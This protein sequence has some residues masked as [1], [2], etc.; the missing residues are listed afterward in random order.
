[1]TETVVVLPFIFVVLSLLIFLGWGM[2]RWHR[3]TQ[4]DRYVAWQQATKAPGPRAH[5]PRTGQLNDAFYDGRV[6][7]LTPQAPRSIPEEKAADAW[8]E[9]VAGE[10]GEAGRL[11]ERVHEQLP[12]RVIAAFQTSHQTTVPLWQD[13]DGPIYHQHTRLD[14]DWRF[15]NHVL[16]DRETTRRY[17]FDN[18]A[19]RWHPLKKRDEG[20]GRFPPTLRRLSAIRDQFLDRLDQQ[21]RP[22]AGGREGQLA[23]HW[24]RLYLQAPDYRGPFMPDEW[25]A[26]YRRAHGGS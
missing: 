14:G 24:R 11:T 18:G 10:H 17:W 3:A 26:N 1:M 2:Q 19:E 7:Q 12:G 23:R 5:G 25:V 16:H 6:G 13:I 20:E 22:V 15:V 21:L 9:R 4:V 8:T